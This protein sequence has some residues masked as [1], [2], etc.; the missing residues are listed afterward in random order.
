MSW[1]YSQ[2]LEAAYS[3]ANSLDGALSAPSN[4]M[5]TQG[6]CSRHDKTTDA[7]NPSQSGMTLQPSTGDR[8]AE[9]LTWFRGASRARTSALPGVALDST[10]NAAAYGEK[11]RASW[12]RFDPLSCSW[13]THQCLWQ[14]DL[15]E[16]SVTLPEWGMMQGGVVSERIMSDSRTEEIGSG[17]WPTPTKFDAI[18]ANMMPK[19][20][21]STR[22]DKHG[23]Q[24]KVLEDGRT[25]SMGFS[26]LIISMTG[27]FPKVEAFEELMGWPSGWTGLRE[28]ATD[29][30][31]QWWLVY[32]ER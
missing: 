24:R 18:L 13:K 32:G 15:P 31:R 7:S 25:A 9:L 19:N 30:F 17:W 26:R 12:V 4:T 16:S 2:A 11:W 14:E 28:S 27:R 1:H 5:N 29:K 20:G 8:G 22:M 21:D 23:K 3:A 10:D 6:T